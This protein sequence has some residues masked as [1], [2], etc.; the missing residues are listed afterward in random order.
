LILTIQHYLH[1]LKAIQRERARA[2]ALLGGRASAA[3][4]DE[5]A[6]AYAPYIE[7]AVRAVGDNYWQI[8]KW[9]TRNDV[10][11]PRRGRWSSQGLKNIVKRYE[12][13]SGKRLVVTRKVFPSPPGRK[14]AQ[15]R[16][17]STSALSP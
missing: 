4:A 13:L 6:L 9:L 15:G 8:A 3:K 2:T 11:T 14:L 17:R 10:P 5:H 12:K 16:A 1:Q 7:A